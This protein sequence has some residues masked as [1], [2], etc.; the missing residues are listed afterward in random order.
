MRQT[1]LAIACLAGIA[2]V[3]RAASAGEPD[4]KIVR[5]WRAKCASCHGVDG[6]GGTD[7]GKKLEIPDF[8]GAQ[9]KKTFSEPTMKKSVSE[10]LKREGKAD[11]MDAYKDKLTPEQIDGLIAYVRDLK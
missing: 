7:Q 10:G 3:S 9:W 8:T 4:P 11:G 2:L 6:K 1:L 5:T